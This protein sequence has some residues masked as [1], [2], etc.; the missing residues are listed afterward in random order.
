VASLSYGYLLAALVFKSILLGAS[1]RL[2]ITIQANTAFT[3]VLFL[4]AV[5]RKSSVCPL[6]ACSVFILSMT[7]F[8]DGSSMRRFELTRT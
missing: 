2:F 6:L 4:L 7:W 1:D 3:F 5:F 8:L